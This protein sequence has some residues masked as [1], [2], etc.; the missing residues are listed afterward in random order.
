MWKESPQVDRTSPLQATR[1]RL[2]S[3][4]IRTFGILSITAYLLMFFQLFDNFLVLRSMLYVLIFFIVFHFLYLELRRLPIRYFIFVM[5]GISLIEALFI[6]PNTF[7]IA[8]ILTIN[9]WI[10]MLAYNL[11]WESH[12][13]LVWSSMGYF[14]VWGYIFTVFITVWYSLFV[15]WY[16]NKFPFT[17][18]TLSD[19]SS[20]V[21]N[22]FTQPVTSGIEKIKADTNALLNTPVKDVAD[23]GTNVSLQTEQSSYSMIIQKFNTYKKNLIDQAFKDNS[24]FNMG[25]CDYLLGQ[26]NT[27]YT[28]PAFKTSVILLMFLLLY[29]FVRIVFRAMTAIAFLIFKILY[30]LNVYHTHTVLKEAEELE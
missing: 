9:A 12:D 26:M 25:I 27:I 22:V 3:R 18:Q 24:T 23:I 28:N 2:H 1:K 6:G 8:S 11:Q 13:K 14:N 29:G 21:I 10:V 7:L 19:A 5:L 20:R 16:Y 4:K 17:C 30:V 15:L